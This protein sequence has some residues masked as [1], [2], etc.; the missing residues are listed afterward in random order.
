[1]RT[2]H[3]FRA[4]FSAFFAVLAF[5]LVAP[6][7]VNADEVIAA[8]EQVLAPAPAVLSWDETSG[9]GSVEASRANR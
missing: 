8:E 2:I 6:I 5:A 1:M 3:Q 4:V 7:A 9:Y